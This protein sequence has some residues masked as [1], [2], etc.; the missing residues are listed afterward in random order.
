MRNAPSVIFP[1]GRCPF[2]ALLLACF[3][4]LL[5][6]VLALAWSGLTRW[7]AIGLALAVLLWWVV[8]AR[9]VWRQPAGWLRFGGANPRP[10]PE[11]TA[12]AWQG[13][14]GSDGI[15]VAAPR[16]VLDLQVR[17]LLQVGGASGVPRWIWLE[18]SRSPADWLALRRAL[19]VNPAS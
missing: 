11:D 5:A 8:A 10:L 2:W 15:P 19:L 18:A 6:G 7:Q 12:W 9:C 14:P 1:V 3:A 16:L 4:L 13:E 17:L